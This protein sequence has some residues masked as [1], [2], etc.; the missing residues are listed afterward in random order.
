MLKKELASRL[1]N[2]TSAIGN[3]ISIGPNR[4]SVLESLYMEFHT[5]VN[6]RNASQVYSPTHYHK[7][8]STEDAK[9]VIS[10]LSAIFFVHV[11]SAR[12]SEMYG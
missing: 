5:N 11:I 12:H 10:D 9:D 2:F 4:C 7:R 6:D 1:Y 3:L 8:I